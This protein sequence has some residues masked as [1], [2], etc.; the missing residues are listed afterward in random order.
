MPW[1][2]PCSLA[3]RAV[4][5]LSPWH[6]SHVAASRAAHGADS[7]WTS[8]SR[9]GMTVLFLAPHSGDKTLFD[10]YTHA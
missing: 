6:R 2:R 3:P 8:P 7:G 9:D 5:V 4:P 10:A 1:L